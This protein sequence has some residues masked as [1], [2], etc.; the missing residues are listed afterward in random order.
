MM[1]NDLDCWFSGG[2]PRARWNIRSV[3]RQSTALSSTILRLITSP[4]SSGAIAV[5]AVR[6]TTGVGAA[7]V[8]GGGKLLNLRLAD[9]R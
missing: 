4:R 3:S 7:G 9:G 1:R 2:R 6:D 8:G 5:G